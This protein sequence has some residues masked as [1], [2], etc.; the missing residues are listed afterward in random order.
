MEIKLDAFRLVVMV[1]SVVG[2]RNSKPATTSH[3]SELE[4]AKQGELV[5]CVE[6]ESRHRHER[7]F[8]RI[9]R[10]QITI[11]RNTMAS[12]QLAKQ[13]RELTLSNKP[14]RLYRSIIR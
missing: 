13:A 6:M 9:H 7:K 8:H 1:A 14:A 5:K 10:R 11:V 2:S 3:Q 12:L 4:F